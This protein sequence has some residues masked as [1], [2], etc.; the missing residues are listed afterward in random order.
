MR[1]L[2][3][4]GIRIER[5]IWNVA[6]VTESQERM[7]LLDAFADVVFTRRRQIA[8]GVDVVGQAIEKMK[9]ISNGV[10]K[11]ALDEGVSASLLCDLM[12]RTS[13]YETL[14]FSLVAENERLRGRLEVLSERASHGRAQQVPV[15]PA[16][17]RKG[18]PESTVSSTPELPRPVETWSLVV[19]SKTAAMR[20]FDF[21]WNVLG[22]YGISDHNPIEVCVTHTSTMN[23]SV[24]GNRWRT[25]G[26]NWSMHGM[27]V[28][29]EATQVDLGSF[30]ALSVDE[31][32]VLVNR[33]MTSANDRMFERHRKVNLKRVKWWTQ[34][35]HLNSTLPTGMIDPCRLEYIKLLTYQLIAQGFQPIFIRV[36][37]HR[38]SGKP[39]NLFEV[40]LQPTTDGTNERILKLER[41]GSQ[42]VIIEKQL[43][44]ID[45]VH[46]IVKSGN[47]IKSSSQAASGAASRHLSQFQE[48]L[49]A[50]QQ[51]QKQQLQQQEQHQEQPDNSLRLALQLNTETIA[52]M[53][54]KMDA[55]LESIKVH[56]L[57]PVF[58][59]S[60]K[61]DVATPARIDGGMPPSGNHNH[62]N[63]KSSLRRSATP[64]PASMRRSTNTANWQQ[65][66]NDDDNKSPTSYRMLEQV[67]APA[68][69]A[70]HC[71]PI[72]TTTND[73]SVMLL[74]ASNW[75]LSNCQSVTM[76][77]SW[78]R[79]RRRQGNPQRTQQFLHKRPA[80]LKCRFCGT[81]LHYDDPWRLLQKCEKAFEFVYY[82]L[83]FIFRHI[84]CLRVA[85]RGIPRHHLQPGRYWSIWRSLIL[86]R[87]PH[88]GQQRQQQQ[89]Q[90][91][92]GPFP[93]PSGGILATPEKQQNQQQRQQRRQQQRRQ[94]RHQQKQQQRHQRRQRQRH[95][96]C[97]S[98]WPRQWQR[99]MA[100]SRLRV[101][102]SSSSS[103][104]TGVRA[105]QRRNQQR[106]LLGS[107]SVPSTGRAA[108]LPA[109]APVTAA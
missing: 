63:K 71:I 14:L 9:A 33:W 24:G 4:L 102:A 57:P 52:L 78:P 5:G 77:D 91:R 61:T 17:A 89:Q 64:D 23:E 10:L 36:I 31:Q 53:G 29:E 25:R 75:S 56:K 72:G 12:D 99:G 15:P 107:G 11:S 81:G 74:R 48:K 59:N 90:R 41:V 83:F 18:G 84:K 55:M 79:Q 97:K 62:N 82:I 13:A 45:P 35:L 44:R 73:G 20:M 16:A 80:T 95:A 26:A 2:D 32:V 43:K 7:Q 92:R 76:G 109:A 34:A 47:G 88:L 67:A 60:Y 8:E 86:E 40:E 104:W 105:I 65:Q 37:K 46:Q 28:R 98:L 101:A 87:N 69:A 66:N 6:G 93:C 51:V 21:S 30:R 96:G 58:C 103:N 94:R 42:D 70:D 3:G 39:M 22:G 49:R 100:A 106:A 50:E 85:K 19:R 54:K 1:F 38:F 68:V 27:F 108:L